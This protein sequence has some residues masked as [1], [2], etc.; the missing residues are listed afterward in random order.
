MGWAK[1]AF[2][3]P[4]QNYNPNFWYEVTNADDYIPGV[5]DP[6]DFDDTLRYAIEEI[7]GPRNI[8][9]LVNGTITLKSQL[10][11]DDQSYV[12]ITGEYAT[13]IGPTIIG[14]EFRIKDCNNIVLRYM[15]FRSRENATHHCARSLLILGEDEGCNDVIVDHCSIGASRDDNISVYGKLCRVTVQNCIIGGGMIGFSRAG[16]GS[17]STSAHVHE[18]LTYCRNLIT[19]TSDRQLLFFGPGRVDF[20]NNIVSINKSAMQLGAETGTY[21]PQINIIK[22]H[23]RTANAFTRGAYFEDPIRAKV[24]A[25][26]IGPGNQELPVSSNGF[27][28]HLNGNLYRKYNVVEQTYE[29]P[30]ENQ[31][32]LTYDLNNHE[33]HEDPPP[34]EANFPTDFQKVGAWDMPSDTILNAVDVE[35]HVLANAGCQLPTSQPTW[36]DYDSILVESAMIDDGSKP[37]RVFPDTEPDNDGFPGTPALTYPAHNA[38]GVSTSV[39][40]SWIQSDETDDYEVFLD[41]NIFPTTS[42]GVTSNT[43]IQASNLQ[44][45]TLYRWRIVA[46]D[47]C[48]NTSGTQSR[49]FTTE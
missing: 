43:Q 34:G 41:T 22:N 29:D 15:R 35:A 17:G 46:R 27:S 13:G 30:Y 8:K 23:F 40:L 20:F 44:A 47:S 10:S 16:I 2:A 4:P 37:N 45:N 38:T 3:N 7:S 1:F 5:D 33:G 32:D 6:E 14:D 48:E 11:M 26:P 12:K 31:W 42:I 39:T 25:S 28:I 36:D 18:R 24:V 9:V 49:E 19:N 21:G